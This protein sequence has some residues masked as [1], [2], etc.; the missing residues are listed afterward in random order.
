MG[1]MGGDDNAAS[2]A[3]GRE[4]TLLVTIISIRLRSRSRSSASNSSTTP[5]AARSMILKPKRC[6]GAE[7]LP[8]H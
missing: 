2:R 1:F 6:Y 8:D 7:I 5:P 3:P 4:T